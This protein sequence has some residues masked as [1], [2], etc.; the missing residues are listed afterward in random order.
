MKETTNETG[1]ADRMTLGRISMRKRV[2]ST[3]EGHERKV[4]GNFLVQQVTPSHFF[5][6]LG[7]YQ[8]AQLTERDKQIALL[9]TETGCTQATV[10]PVHSLKADVEPSPIQ[11]HHYYTVRSRNTWRVYLYCMVGHNN[12]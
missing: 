10:S 11:T 9:M 12:I 2:K 1:T 8:T 5:Q 6:D 3:G 4:K 7:N